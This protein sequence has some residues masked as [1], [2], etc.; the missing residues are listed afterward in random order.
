MPINLRNKV[1]GFTAALAGNYETSMHFWPEEF[2]SPS[3]VALWREMY[4][5]SG[6]SPRFGTG[7]QDS[8]SV[9]QR[10]RGLLG[11][12][13]NWSTFHKEIGLP[14]CKQINQF[15]VMAPKNI[16]LIGSLGIVFRPSGDTL[17]LFLYARDNK[18]M[19][20]LV[21]GCEAIGDPVVPGVCAQAA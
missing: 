11:C 2:A 5:P 3:G 14:G 19:R 4:H 10:F 18:V 20:D 15:P 21:A 6:S 1:D 17:G 16:H 12:V 13:T 7:R 8:P 9:L